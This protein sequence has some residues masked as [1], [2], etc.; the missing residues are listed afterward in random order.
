LPKV[1][2]HTSAR[3]GLRRLSQT[4]HRRVVEVLRELEDDPRPPGCAKLRAGLGWK[5]HVGD[6]RI[7][8]TI[9]DA[10]QRVDVWYIGP[11]GG[12]Y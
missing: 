7:L 6:Y 12:A 8:Y 11:R 5:I 10:A 1:F 2:L 3:Q 4:A 9:D